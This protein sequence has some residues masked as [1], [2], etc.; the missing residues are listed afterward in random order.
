MSVSPKERTLAPA[1]PWFQVRTIRL[2]FGPCRSGRRVLDALGDVLARTGL[3]A[4]H[5]DVNLGLGGY[6]L[7]V[8]CDLDVDTD[9]V[10][11]LA[12]LHRPQPPPLEPPTSGTTYRPCS[13]SR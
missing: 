5:V 8:D 3:V 2:E 4:R 1:P 10:S 9:V 6:S 7:V 12:V 11:V 13:L